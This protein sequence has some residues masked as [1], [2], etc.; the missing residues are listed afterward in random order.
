M[1]AT[2]TASCISTIRGVEL[3]GLQSAASFC[4]RLAT[5]LRRSFDNR[6][7]RGRGQARK[8]VSPFD[9]ERCICFTASLEYGAGLGCADTILIFPISHDL[10][11]IG[12]F[13]HGG[14]SNVVND[15]IVAAVSFTLFQAAMR[16]VHASSDFPVMDVG[17]A[18]RPFPRARFG[19]A[20]A[21][22]RPTQRHPVRPNLCRIHISAL[23]VIAAIAGATWLSQ[24]RRSGKTASR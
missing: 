7:S 18:V 10:A 13:E 21:S 15:S 17:K 22:V 8:L 1:M 2:P 24:C 9:H 20:C 23:G 5:G 12:S 3:N 19:G 14:G 4:A 11:V 16:Q 6:G